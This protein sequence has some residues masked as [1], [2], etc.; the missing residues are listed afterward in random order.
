LLSGG[1]DR[2]IK[3]WDVA[4][5]QTPAEPLKHHTGAVTSVCFD[6]SGN[7]VITGGKDFQLCIVDLRSSLTVTSL[8][9]ILG[10]ISSVCADRSFTHV[11]AGMKNSVN[12]IWD[13]R[14]TGCS[15]LLKGHQ[16]SVKA[17]IRVRF[18]A[19]ERTVVGGSE[20]GNICIWDPDSG[21]LVG[22]VEGHPEGT[23][24][25]VFSDEHRI[26]A[27]CGSDPVI[28]LWGQKTLTAPDT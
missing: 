9:P 16:N 1:F 20:D 14:K 23:F 6:S 7:M 10:E 13:L 24:E 19:D 4:T 28:R 15:L 17:F 21:L 5:G 25:M 8:Q 18:G 26:F 12:R 11:L 22:R 2:K 27:S 3:I